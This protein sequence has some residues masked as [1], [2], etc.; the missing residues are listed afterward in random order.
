MLRGRRGWE[1]ILKRGEEWGKTVNQ[2]CPDV[3]FE[4]Y[5]TKGTFD[6]YVNKETSVTV[7]LFSGLFSL[8]L[9]L[10]LLLRLRLLLLRLRLYIHIYLW[11]HKVEALT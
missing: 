4:N 1:K 7:A 10:L 8:C 9:L 6:A 11:E 5:I 3:S 2:A